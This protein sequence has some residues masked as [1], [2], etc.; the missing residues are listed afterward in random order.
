MLLIPHH[1]LSPFLYLAGEGR[2][3]M[4]WATRVR[5]AAGAARGI[6]YLHE[7]CNFL[8]FISG[9]AYFYLFALCCLYIID[10]YVVTALILAISVHGHIL[11]LISS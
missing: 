10:V 5:V 3:V 11:S 2:P 6:A 1:A 9:L 4:E 7:D 8:V